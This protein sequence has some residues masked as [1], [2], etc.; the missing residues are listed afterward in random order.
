MTEFLSN[1]KPLVLDP[2]AVSA[3]PDAP[4]FVAPPKGAPAYY[5][6]PILDDVA[7]EGFRL[8]LITA[9]EDEPSDW[10]DAFIV[11][12]DDSRAG[13]VWEAGES[14]LVQEIRAPEPRRWGVWGV[15]FPHPMISHENARKNLAFVLPLLKKRW[16][17]WK[18]SKAAEERP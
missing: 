14:S 12:P 7:A 1:G 11:A 15:S 3:S 2:N 10:G 13:L 18:S 17:E 9:L 16:E 6:F 8:G 4:A 5:G